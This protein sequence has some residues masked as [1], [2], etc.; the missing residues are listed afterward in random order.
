MTTHRQADLP[1]DLAV[2]RTVAQHHQALVGVYAEVAQPG[3]VRVGDPV[4]L[5]K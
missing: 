2:L 1:R 4:T 5:I 3:G